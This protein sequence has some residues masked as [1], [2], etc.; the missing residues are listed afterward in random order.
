MNNDVELDFGADYAVDFDLKGINGDAKA[1]I[2]RMYPSTLKWADA[3]NKCTNKR[4]DAQAHVNEHLNKRDCKCK[5][6]FLL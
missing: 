5:L 6:C 2:A 4:K 3:G 1:T